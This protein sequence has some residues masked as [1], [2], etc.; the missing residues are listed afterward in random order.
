MLTT[1]SHASHDLHSRL[2]RPPQSRLNANLSVAPTGG[3]MTLRWHDRPGRPLERALPC[4]VRGPV[5]R[6][7]SA[8]ESVM[9]AAPF[10]GSGELG[11]RQRRSR[12][13]GASCGSSTLEETSNPAMAARNLPQ[14]LRSGN[15]RSSPVK[16]R[17]RVF[18]HPVSVPL[19]ARTT[20]T[21]NRSRS[22]QGRL[23]APRK[24]TEIEARQ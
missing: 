17:K 14:A 16:A 5:A 19:I 15:Q 6:C 8:T 10:A 1:G 4:G 3:R 9:V 21:P 2:V 18:L 13:P 20:N 23:T 7:D 11:L 24:A 22:R 12:Q